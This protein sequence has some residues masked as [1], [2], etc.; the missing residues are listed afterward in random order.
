MSLLTAKVAPRGD[1]P[2]MDQALVRWAAARELP[3]DALESWRDQLTTV[4]DAVTVA[5]LR[6]AI[7]AR[8]TMR[9]DLA[10]IRASYL[11]G[12]TARVEAHLN[13]AGSSRLLTARNAAWLPVLV[14]YVDA[15]GAFAAVGVSHLLG[16][17]GLPAL[18]AAR[19]YTVER[20]AGA[21]S[22]S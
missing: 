12:A 10:V 1:A 16:P 9:C 21:V 11:A 14:A 19:G 17:E 15:D 2:T 22:G 20:V 18:L 4:A 7:A 5:D 3:I 6:D 8:A 13:V